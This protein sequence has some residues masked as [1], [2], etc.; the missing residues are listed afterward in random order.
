MTIFL[1]RS[2]VM[3]RRPST[4][5][6]DV[7]HEEAEYRRLRVTVS[8]TATTPVSETTAAHRLEAKE[9]LFRF[10]CHRNQHLFSAHFLYITLGAIV[11]VATLNTRESRRNSAPVTEQQSHSYNSSSFFEL[12]SLVKPEL[13]VC[14]SS[15]CPPP[16]TWSWDSPPPSPLSVSVTVD[17]N[18][19]VDL[20]SCRRYPFPLQTQCVVIF[21]SCYTL[22]PFPAETLHHHHHPLRG[23]RLPCVRLCPIVSLRNTV[24]CSP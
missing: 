5:T 14:F 12:T 15:L 10:V 6:L 16:I 23:R 8:A 3:R 19:N 17:T 7:N 21:P 24:L 20:S 11:A 22:L 2:G 18:L 13:A 1:E 4:S 9:L